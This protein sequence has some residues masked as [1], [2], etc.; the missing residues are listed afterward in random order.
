MPLATFRAAD[1]LAEDPAEGVVELVRDALL[2][3]NDGVVRDMDILRA[4]LRAALRDV[5]E[6]DACRL[7]DEIGAVFSVQRMHLQLRQPHKEARPVE[8]LFVLRV[9]GDHVEDVL[10]EKA[11]D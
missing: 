8:L 5:A 7:A 3:R 11:L 4:D 9:V 2:E 6:T 1:E 10:A